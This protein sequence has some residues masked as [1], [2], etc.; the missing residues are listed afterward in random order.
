MPYKY[1]HIVEVTSMQFGILANVY[2]CI[3]SVSG[4]LTAPPPTHVLMNFSKASVTINPLRLITTLSPAQSRGSNP[5]DLQHLNQDTN[6]TAQT[7]RVSKPYKHSQIRGTRNNTEQSTKHRNPR[8]PTTHTL[9]RTWKMVM[10]SSAQNH[11]L[12]D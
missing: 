10:A 1:L 5:K 4:N 9:S 8:E 12:F 3:Y 11:H 6:I 7:K 2:F